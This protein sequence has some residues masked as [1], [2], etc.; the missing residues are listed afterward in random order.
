MRR[1]LGIAGAALA[2]LLLVVGLGGSFI[3]TRALPTVNGEYRLLG[4]RERGE[5]VRDVYGVPHVYAQNAHDLFFLQGYVTAQDRLFQLDLY[6][7]TGQ[8]RLSEVLGEPALDTDKFTRTLGLARAA[9]ADLAVAG[10]TTRDALDAYAEGVNKLLDQ[11]KDALPLEFVILG[12]RPEPW[13][14]L[15]SLTVIKLEA[16]DL[17]GNFRTELLR[18]DIVQRLGPAALAT[19]LPDADQSPPVGLVD[20][21]WAAVAPLLSGGR[22]AGAAAAL[23]S[24]GPAAGAVASDP[25]LGAGGPEGSNC[26]AVA[27]GRSRTGLPLLAGD[28]HLGVRNPAIWYEVGLEGAGYK[29]VGFAIPG[30]PGVLTGHNAHLAWSF[31]IAYTDVQ[32]IYVEQQD[33]ADFRRYMYRGASEAAT[34]L[35][36]MIRVKGRAEPLALDVA[37]TR[38]GP[39]VTGVLPGRTSQLALRWNALDAGHTADGLLALNRAEDFR[40]FRAATAQFSGATLSACYADTAGHIAYQFVGSLPRRT[41]GDG[42]LPVPGWTGDHEWDGQVSPDQVPWVLDPAAGYVVNANDRPTQDPASAAFVGEWDPGFRAARLGAQ[43]RDVRNADVE[44]FRAMEIDFSSA[45]ALRFR[46]V[47]AGAAARSPL[48][49][50]TQALVRD[51]DGVPSADSAAAAVYEAWLVRMCERVF[52][53]KLGDALFADYENYGRPSFALYQLSPRASDP[54]FE[55]LGDPIGR[56]R[57][58]MAA[59]AL[60][61]ASR[62]LRDAL[63]PDPDRWRW[64]DLHRVRFDHPLSAVPPLD[65]LF[66]IGPLARSGDMYS[67]NNGAY[68]FG[69]PY[70]LSSHSSYR[71]IVDLADTDRS[72]SVLPTGESGQPFARHWGD[73][74]TLWAEGRL[75]AMRFSRERL[76][77]I[78]GTLQFRP[79]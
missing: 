8:G 13:S 33:P 67:V 32:D 5:V 9:V 55:E 25:L 20:G 31:T 54:F 43:L 62:D 12:Y 21:S 64:G 7:R 38:H 15:D 78:E 73:Q 76:G 23:P 51:W 2:V 4:L 1:R 70:L 3:V 6:R 57:D 77:Q 30:I 16:Y 18:A 49:A 71:M 44:G 28:P 46:D 34:I 27:G 19:L 29:V 11:Q 36:E 17:A 22:A 26:W 52:K 61:D 42:R 74:T 79:R 75:K 14:A 41:A 39:I 24:A 48:A 58:E 66:S 63:G 68:K 65:R 40:A 45:P 69:K 59:R 10:G 53:D 56:G 35:R 37:I 60:D 47:I 50:R 72:W